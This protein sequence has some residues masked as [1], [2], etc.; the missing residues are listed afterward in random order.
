MHNLTKV[1]LWLGNKQKR[2]IWSSEHG[3]YP[4]SDGNEL[5]KR[6][7]TQVMYFECL[8]AHPL[9]LYSSHKTDIMITIIIRKNN[10]IIIKINTRAACFKV[11]TLLHCVFYR[12][13]ESQSMNAAHFCKYIA[14]DLLLMNFDQCL[15]S[16]FILQY[17]VDGFK[18]A[19]FT[20]LIF[21]N[22]QSEI[23]KHIHFKIRVTMCFCLVYN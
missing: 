10:N 12:L 22:Q 11:A 8:S 21:L 1:V 19:Y 2:S 18:S 20:S 6:N 7:T 17:A 16:M 15:L 3:N 13:A 14:C 5:Q 4:S 23:A 9:L